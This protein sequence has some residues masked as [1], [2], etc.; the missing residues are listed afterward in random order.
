MFSRIQIRNRPRARL[1]GPVAP[2]ILPQEVV[3]VGFVYDKR[4]FGCAWGALCFKGGHPNVWIIAKNPRHHIRAC[5]RARLLEPFVSSRRSWLMKG[6]AAEFLSFAARY[7]FGIIYIH[8]IG[9]TVMGICDFGVA[10]P[11]GG[12]ILGLP[13]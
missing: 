2:F 11:K 8:C 10:I 4:D 3:V 13:S 6:G 9:K 1:M 12:I 7:L 5:F